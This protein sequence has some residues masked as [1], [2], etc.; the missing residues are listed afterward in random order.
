MKTFTVSIKYKD[1]PKK[2]LKKKCKNHVGETG[3]SK[4]NYSKHNNI[5]S[6]SIKIW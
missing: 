2:V 6:N 4:K 3:E 5:V 1:F